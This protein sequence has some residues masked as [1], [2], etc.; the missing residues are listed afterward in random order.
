[1]GS[2][3]DFLTDFMLQSSLS[4]SSEHDFVEDRKKT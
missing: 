4:N 1:M 3:V 2:T